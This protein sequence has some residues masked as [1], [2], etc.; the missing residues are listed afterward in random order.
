MVVAVVVTFLLHCL[1]DSFLISFV[2]F[3]FA[4]LLHKTSLECSIYTYPYNISVV[5]VFYFTFVFF[6]RQ[7]QEKHTHTFDS[8]GINKCVMC[9]RAVLQ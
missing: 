8:G 5:Y 3:I 1:F 9:V 6:Y 7:Q 4:L 2:D